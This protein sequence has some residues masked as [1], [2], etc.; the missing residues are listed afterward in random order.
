MAKS[1]P[2]LS[3]I[4]STKRIGADRQSVESDRMIIIQEK[5]NARKQYKYK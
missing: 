2:E 3:F 4:P 5:K 1:Y